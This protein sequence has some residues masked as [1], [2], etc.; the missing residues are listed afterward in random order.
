MQTITVL[1]IFIILISSLTLMTVIS[2]YTLLRS[3]IIQSIGLFT[4]NFIW[5]LFACHSTGTFVI[6]L[7]RIIFASIVSFIDR[8]Y[9]I[10]IK[11]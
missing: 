1:F 3:S 9:N 7:K 5:A 10:L 6:K 4:G 11:L 2:I 8:I